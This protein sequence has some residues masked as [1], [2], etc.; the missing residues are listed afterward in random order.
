MEKLTEDRK[1]TECPGTRTRPE[2][3]DM[4]SEKKAIVKT[5]NTEK[6]PFHLYSRTNERVD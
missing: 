3:D 5:K 1:Y 6:R 4:I 2:Q